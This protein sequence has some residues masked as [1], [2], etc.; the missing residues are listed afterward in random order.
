[1]RN[2]LMTTAFACIGVFAA[3]TAH[4]GI[5]GDTVMIAWLYPNPG[6]IFSQQTATVTS[7]IEVTDLLWHLSVDFTDKQ[8]IL[9]YL[10]DAFYQSDPQVG[11]SFADQTNK[12]LSFTIDN[13][14]TASWFNSTMIDIDSSGQ[15][16]MNLRTQTFH[17]GE[18]VVLNLSTSVPEPAA[19]ALLGAGILGLGAARRRRN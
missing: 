3:A 6:D 1:M 13:T 16:T 11:P 8:L 15:I 14:T 10:D 2:F 12:F 19:L 18:T 9:T 7:A 5:M 17:T 4:A